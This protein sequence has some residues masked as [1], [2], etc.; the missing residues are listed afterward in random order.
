MTKER[1]EIIRQ[2]VIP[3]VKKELLEIN[4]DGLGKFDAKEFEKDLNEVL[5]LAIKSLEQQPSDDCISRAKAIEICENRGHDNS[6]YYISKLPPVTPTHGTCKD[7]KQLGVMD[8]GYY[9][10]VN[11]WGKISKEGNYGGMGDWY[12]ADFNKRG[13]EE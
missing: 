9:C 4:N 3:F 12:C 1:I 5:D 11:H 2:S 8:C 7:C 10:K 6:A 13:S